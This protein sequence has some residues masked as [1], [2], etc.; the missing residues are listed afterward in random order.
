MHSNRVSEVMPHHILVKIYFSSRLTFILLHPYSRDFAN[1]LITDPNALTKDLRRH[2][3]AVI[4]SGEMSIEHIKNYIHL[5]GPGLIVYPPPD[6]Q[7]HSKIEKTYAAPRPMAL[8]HVS[9]IARVMP[10]RKAYKAEGTGTPMSLFSQYNSSL[11]EINVPSSFTSSFTTSHEGNV[12]KK[13]VEECLKGATLVSPHHDKWP[14]YNYF[15]TGGLIFQLEFSRIMDARATS[16]RLVK[17][18][19]KYWFLTSYSPWPMKRAKLMCMYIDDNVNEN[20]VRR[21][22]S[23]TPVGACNRTIWNIATNVHKY[24]QD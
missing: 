3:R 2:S 8:T 12:V 1:R 11:A 4:V 21:K 5:T 22:T 23:Y 9:Y 7:W 10:S 18:N 20:F 17:S 24:I 14:H 16:E 13:R 6:A 15:G 19:S